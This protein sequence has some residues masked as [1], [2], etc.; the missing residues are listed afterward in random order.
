MRPRGDGS[1]DVRARIP[2]HAANRLRAYLNAYTAP[3]RRHLDQ[4]ADDEVARLPFDRQRGE[5]FVALLENVLSA[6]LPRHGGIATTVMVTLDYETLVSGVG[7][8]TTSTGDRLSAGQARRLACQAGILPVVLGGDSEILDVGRTRRLV[9][10]AIRQALNLR[11][12]GCTARGCTMPA[13]FCEA[14]TSCPGPEAARPASRT[15]SCSVRS[16][17]TA[18]TTPAGSRT[19]RPT[20][21]P[22]SPSARD[23]YVSSPTGTSASTRFPGGASGQA[24]AGS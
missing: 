14:T 15:P 18:P 10:D 8:A 12:R 7:V 20:E 16:T 19:T 24:H 5:A 1:T 3:R 2:D 23:V 17:I 22:A 9:T 21:R 4:P 11:D 6:G 13:E